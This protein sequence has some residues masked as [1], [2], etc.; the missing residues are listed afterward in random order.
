MYHFDKSR[1]DLAAEFKGDP[2]GCHSAD[3][4]YLLNFMRRPKDGPFH[5]LV[6]SKP[7]RRWCLAKIEPGAA[8]RPQLTGVEF[9]ELEEA[10]WYVFRER[11]AQ[12]AGE[13]CPIT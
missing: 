13:E 3:L 5:V 9:T 4:H 11:W 6:V 2:Y 8:M 7:G 10:E 1:L 12:L